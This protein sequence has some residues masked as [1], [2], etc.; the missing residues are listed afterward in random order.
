MCETEVAQPS[1]GLNLIKKPKHNL[2]DGRYEIIGYNLGQKMV[3]E[4]C[5]RRWKMSCDDEGYRYWV[6]M[7]RDV[8]W[9]IWARVIKRIGP[10]RACPCVN[11]QKKPTHKPTVHPTSRD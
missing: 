9:L 7:L 11:D 8:P 10:V 5:G 6:R 1:P 3:C 4:G 2:P